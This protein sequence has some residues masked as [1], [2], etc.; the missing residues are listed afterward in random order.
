MS[1]TLKAILILLV[2]GLVVYLLFIRTNKQSPDQGATSQDFLD[3]IENRP[4][5]TPSS[6]IERDE[7]FIFEIEQRER[8]AP[9]ET[10]ERDESFITEIENRPRFV[11]GQ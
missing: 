2:L 3:S 10:V 8:F 11:P 4:R 7:D 1:K 5:F 9:E 6:T